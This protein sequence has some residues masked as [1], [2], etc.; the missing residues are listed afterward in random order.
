MGFPPGFRQLHQQHIADLFIANLAGI[1]LTRD[2]R[3]GEFGEA[4][5]HRLYRLEPVLVHKAAERA[6]LNKKLEK[7]DQPILERAKVR[8]CLPF[9]SPKEGTDACCRQRRGRRA[10]WGT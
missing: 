6:A 10:V 5:R 8:I 4:I 7:C 9:R 1:E 2:N 3:V